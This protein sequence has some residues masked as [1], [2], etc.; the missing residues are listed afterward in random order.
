MRNRRSLTKR[1]L[2]WLYKTTKDELD[3]IDRKFTQLD[4]DRALQRY[5]KARAGGVLA[6]FLQEWE[7]YIAA[8][9]KDAQ[10]LKFD[11]QGRPL[12]SYA[13]LAL[14]LEAVER[15]TRKR[16]GARALAEFRRLYEEAAMKNILQDTSGRR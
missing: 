3:R 1:Y 5:L 4:V 12:A 13:F 11:A 2:F 15:E 14:K 8:K 6:P 10:A 16:F 7:R 9:E